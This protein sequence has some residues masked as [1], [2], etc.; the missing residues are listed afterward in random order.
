[1]VGPRVLVSDWSTA[2]SLQLRSAL[3]NLDDRRYE[4][5][6]SNTKAKVTIDKKRSKIT[7]I[8]NNFISRR[9][10]KNNV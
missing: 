1:M 3:S 2:I 4:K 5:A 9:F 8:N 10:V 7:Y 6:Q